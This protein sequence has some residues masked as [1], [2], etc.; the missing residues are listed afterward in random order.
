MRTLTLNETH[1]VTGGGSHPSANSKSISNPSRGYSKG[2]PNPPDHASI[3]ISG[4]QALGVG[5]A[6]AGSIAAGMPAGAPKAAMA[7]VAAALGLASH[8]GSK[9]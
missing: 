5:A 4:G 3:H 2:G 9:K 1:S 7:G 8:W 6:I